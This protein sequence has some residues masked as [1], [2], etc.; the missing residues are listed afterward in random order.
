MSTNIETFLTCLRSVTQPDG[1]VSVGEPLEHGDYIS[2]I[3]VDFIL[4]ISAIVRGVVKTD[5]VTLQPSE[6]EMVPCIHRQAGPF[7][8]M[9]LLKNEEDV[10]ES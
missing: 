4:T 8:Q 2:Y 9:D 1:I 3:G 10:V 7:I 5:D 6:T